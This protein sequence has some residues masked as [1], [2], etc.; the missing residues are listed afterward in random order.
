MSDIMY[1]NMSD[2]DEQ[3]VKKK[4]K[5]KDEQSIGCNKTSNIRAQPLL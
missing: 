5:I 2:I 4:Q 1:L 3:A